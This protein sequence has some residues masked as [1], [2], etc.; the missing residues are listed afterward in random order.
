[1]TM[2]QRFSMAFLLIFSILII[3]DICLDNKIPTLDSSSVA[4]V[5]VSYDN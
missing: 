3:G 1:M 5:T 4:S 2:I